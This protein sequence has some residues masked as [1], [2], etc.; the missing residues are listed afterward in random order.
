MI[1]KRVGERSEVILSVLDAEIL[2]QIFE[3][4]EGIGIMELKNKLNIAHNSLKPHIDKLTT[5]NLIKQEITPKSRKK[6]LNLTKNIKISNEGLGF[7]I[8]FVLPKKINQ[9]KK[10]F[11]SESKKITKLSKKLK[12]KYIGLKNE[13]S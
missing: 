4:G 8:S 11:E 9:I 12:Q 13:T 1:K 3:S 5:L 6:N 7:V 2:L 10:E